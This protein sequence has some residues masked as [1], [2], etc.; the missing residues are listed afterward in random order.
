MSLLL[1]NSVQTLVPSQ[2]TIDVVGIATLIGM[3]TRDS[4][5]NLTGPVELSITVT[6]GTVTPAFTAEP[7][8]G[9]TFS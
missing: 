2:V 1:L 8:A 6:S 4:Q 7:T 3:L 9:D 5:G